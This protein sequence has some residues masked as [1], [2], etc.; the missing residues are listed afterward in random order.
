MPAHSRNLVLFLVLAAAALLT[1]VLARNTEPE[2]IS[3][4]D[5]AGHA[6]QRVYLGGAVLYGTD[7]EGRIPYRVHAERV[8]QESRE[9][10]FSLQEVRVEYAGDSEIAWG[11]TA[12]SGEMTPDRTLLDL[13]VVRLTARRL[14]E[15][16]S[17]VFV[18]RDLSLNLHEKT[19]STRRPVGLRKDQCESNARGLNVDLNADTY[20]L[21][22][23]ETVCRTRPRPAPLPVLV[24]ALLAQPALAQDEPAGQTFS[25]QCFPETG[26]LINN[27]YTC[28]DAVITDNESFRLTTGLATVND[29]RGLQ[30]ADSEW[31]LTEGLRLDFE[32]AVL[33]AESARFVFDGDGMLRSFDLVGTPAEFSD[34]VEGLA[35]P[36]RVRAQRIL[37]DQEAS[38][39]AMTGE[40]EFLDD[41]NED[42]VGHACELTY[43]LEEK[44]YVI[45]NEQCASMLSLRPTA[46]E[47]SNGEPPDEP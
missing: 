32:T 24:L 18:A 8:E 11:I 21:L 6:P 30:F 25:K 29:K 3:E 45:G 37:Y 2:P 40:V 26:D 19:A 12:A 28:K 23:N 7:D 10:N 39:L 31:L 22:D 9:H 20:E 47:D 34:F 13:S 41:S 46:A 1:W 33:V 16:D 15:A 14:D 42:N 17:F 5:S 4:Q 36:V 43:W 38:T 44:R 35:A 27:V